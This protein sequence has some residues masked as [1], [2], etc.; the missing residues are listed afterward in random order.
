MI[1]YIIYDIILDI[2]IDITYDIIHAIITQYDIILILWPHTA[3]NG[4]VPLTPEKTA[5]AESPS[6]S[7]SESPDKG[8]NLQQSLIP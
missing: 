5:P 6:G 8:A 7:G 4:S 1:S 2:I 3:L